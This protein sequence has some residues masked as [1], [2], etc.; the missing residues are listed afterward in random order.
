M[1]GTAGHR[2]GAAGRTA[3]APLLATALVCAAPAPVV[4]SDLH[5]TKAPPVSER[6]TSLVRAS[7]NAKMITIRLRCRED[8]KVTIA[9]VAPKR[10]LGSTR[11]SCV[12]GRAVARMR[13]PARAAR[14][15]RARGSIDAVATVVSGAERTRFE[16][17]TPSRGG[18]KRV[19]RASSIFDAD[20]WCTGVGFTMTLDN[21]NR[22]DAEWGETV[23][24]RTVGIEQNMY[25]GAVSTRYS[26]YWQSHRAVPGDGM[27]L[28]HPSGWIEFTWTVTQSAPYYASRYG[29]WV[30]PRFEVYTARGGYR[31]YRLGATSGYGYGETAVSSCAVPYPAGY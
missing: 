17:R 14:S 24:W 21:T 18:G 23:W 27:F 9:T 3:V 15:A 29:V 25:S 20:A 19:A 5:A 31:L 16:L 26:A 12:N 13:V 8:G 4:A 2:S 30:Y 11:F 10:R 7:G 1:K 28:I 6:A 22:F